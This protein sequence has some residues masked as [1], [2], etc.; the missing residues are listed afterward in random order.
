MFGNLSSN[1]S[2]CGIKSERILW[3]KMEHC[4][5]MVVYHEMQKTGHCLL[6][7]SASVNGVRSQTVKSPILYRQEVA[8]MMLCWLVVCHWYSGGT[9]YLHLQRSVKRNTCTVH[10][11]EQEATRKGCIT[12]WAVMC[13]ATQKFPFSLSSSTPLYS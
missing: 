11:K 1:G 10:E 3:R 5:T 7:K 13:T 8:D 4:V 12:G 2:E 9:C 6:H